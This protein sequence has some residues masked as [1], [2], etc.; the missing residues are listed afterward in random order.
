M[1]FGEKL[2]FAEVADIDAGSANPRL[3]FS[4]STRRRRVGALDD[5]HD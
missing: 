5:E 2:G 3:L 4:A 1:P